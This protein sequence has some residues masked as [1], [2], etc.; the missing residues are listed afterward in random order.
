MVRKKQFRSEIMKQSK[1]E[2]LEGLQKQ[3][4]QLKYS[5]IAFYHWLQLFRVVSKEREERQ[6]QA[7]QKCVSIDAKN[8]LKS[9]FT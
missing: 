3:Y 8:T 5:S 2:K 9:A 7:A 6:K 1:K 4:T